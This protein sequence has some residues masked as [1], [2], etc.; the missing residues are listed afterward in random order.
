MVFLVFRQQNHTIQALVQVEDQLVSKKMVRFAES[1]NP[2]AI[3]LV[4]GTVQKP[5]EL[6][7]GCTVQDA[8]IKIKEVSLSYV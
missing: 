7:K 5:L 6:V 8:E 3:V 4:K 2:E 1:I